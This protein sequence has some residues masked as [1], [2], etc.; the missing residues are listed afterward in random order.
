MTDGNTVSQIT[1]DVARIRA[2]M[3]LLAVK[4]R[5]DIEGSVLKGHSYEV[6]V[7]GTGGSSSTERGLDALDHAPT[8]AAV[9]RGFERVVDELEQLAG[10]VGVVTDERRAERRRQVAAQFM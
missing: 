6:R 10:G 8:Y 2:L 3:D 7:R 4:A 9:A 5:D 1:D